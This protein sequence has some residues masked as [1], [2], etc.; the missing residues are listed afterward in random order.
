M[1]RC[2]VCDSVR[3]VVVVS[4]QRRAFCTGC[5]ARWIQDG[6]RQRAIRAPKPAPAVGD[7]RA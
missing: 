3:I 4:P 7:R 1:P 2:P 6:A 5:G